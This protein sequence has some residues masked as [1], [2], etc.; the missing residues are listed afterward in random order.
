M[1]P[2]M[3]QVTEILEQ[4]LSLLELTRM[5]L[6][7]NKNPGS[8]KKHWLTGPLHSDCPKDMYCGLAYA[9]LN[10][11]LVYCEPPVPS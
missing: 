7:A 3:K 5:E 8:T 6:S 4:Y 9:W 10:D 2:H 1:T 11:I